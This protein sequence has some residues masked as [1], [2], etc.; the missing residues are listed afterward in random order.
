[1]RCARV[2]N[3]HDADNGKNEITDVPSERTL[4]VLNED[5]HGENVVENNTGRFQQFICSFSNGWCMCLLYLYLGIDFQISSRFPPV[6][7]LDQ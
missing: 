2:C 1:M 6:V 5:L 7:T 3:Y 4:N